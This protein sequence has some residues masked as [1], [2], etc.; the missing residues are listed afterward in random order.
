MRQAWKVFSNDG[1]K[2]KR[3]RLVPLLTNL[4]RNCHR[5]TPH[6]PAGVMVEKNRLTDTVTLKNECRVVTWFGYI[7]CNA[8]KVALTG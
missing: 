3:M 8:C 4:I 1:A 2:K 6:Y 7:D 5:A